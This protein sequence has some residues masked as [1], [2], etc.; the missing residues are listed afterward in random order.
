MK[1][2]ALLEL[3][4]NNFSGNWRRALLLIMASDHGY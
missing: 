2:A 3:P 4:G 1:R